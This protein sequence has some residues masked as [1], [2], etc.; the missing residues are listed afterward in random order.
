VI[1]MMEK[2]VER[3]AGESEVL[4]ENLSQCRFV[5]HKTH[6]LPGREPRP[7]RWEANSNR[8]SYGTA[9]R[10]NVNKWS[11]SFRG[12]FTPSKEPMVQIR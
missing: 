2:L 8:L 3:L 9:F 4:G 5:H 12:R 1:L 10:V 7:L 11:A 6:M